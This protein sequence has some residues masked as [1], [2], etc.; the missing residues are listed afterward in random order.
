MVGVGMVFL[1]GDASAGEAIGSG[2]RRSG[3]S[4]GAR[5]GSTGGKSKGRTV[6]I[7]IGHGKSRGRWLW[8]LRITVVVVS[9]PALVVRRVRLGHL[10]HSIHAT[11]TRMAICHSLCNTRQAS[12]FCML[13]EIVHS[14]RDFRER[15]IVLRC[16]TRIVSRQ[17]RW[18]CTMRRGWRRCNIV[19]GRSRCCSPGRRL[20]TEQSSV[21][22]DRTSLR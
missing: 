9:R 3:R 1:E 14:S 19:A 13:A 10:S 15:A 22:W 20:I 12:T 2:T 8:C 6:G 4:D 16:M 18:A 21:W 17:P 11:V 5:S 7:A